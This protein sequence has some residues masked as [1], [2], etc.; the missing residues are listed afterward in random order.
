MT[1][2]TPPAKNA[3]GRRA[4]F[5]LAE[6]II[7]ASL[8]AI[9]LAGVL[10]TFLFLART[11]FNTAAYAEMSSTLRVATERFHRDVRLASDVRW[12][13]H[14]RLT[15]LIPSAENA[16]HE[17][18]TYGYAPADTAQGEFYREVMHQETTVR[19][20]LARGVAPDFSFRRYRLADA[21]DEAPPAANDLETKLVE[22]SLRAVRRGANGAPVTQD[23]LSTRCL[24]RNKS[25]AQ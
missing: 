21:S 22:V 14:Q 20:V 5:T 19:T 6:V 18:V 1:T 15:L 10:S 17:N 23:A 3:A 11:G 8:S 2:T 13:D 24:L 9:V 25:V 12:H 16:G 7:A 4:A